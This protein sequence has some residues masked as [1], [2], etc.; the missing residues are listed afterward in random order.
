MRL[1]FVLRFGNVGVLIQFFLQIFSRCISN[2]LMH[3]P[4]KIQFFSTSVK[5]RGVIYGISSSFISQHW[6]IIRQRRTV[7]TIFS[8]ILNVEITQFR[9]YFN[10]QLYQLCSQN[11]QFC[12]CGKEEVNNK[13]VLEHA[14]VYNCFIYSLSVALPPTLYKVYS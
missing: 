14:L 11:S 6:Q 2:Y 12:I 13:E 1:F 9:R 8:K 5:K 3:I 10:Y 4:S 7:D